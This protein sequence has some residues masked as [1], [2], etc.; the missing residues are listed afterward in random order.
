MNK[1][2]QL[3][4]VLSIFLISIVIFSCKKGQSDNKDYNR[5]SVVSVAAAANL[6]D[7]LEE[8]KEAYIKENSG[9]K[10]E[11]S[12]ASS[13]LLVQQI[14]NGAPFDLFL[15]ADTSFP[16]KLKMNNK[17]F[18]NSSVYTYGRTA[19]WSSNLDVSEGLKIVLNPKVKKIAIANPKLAPYGKNAVEALKKS[20][21]YTIIEHKIVWA[22]NINQAAQ[23][24][25]SGNADVAF[26]ALSNVMGKEMT[27]KGKFYE[28]SDNESS[29]I[30]QSGIILKGKKTTE[31]QF[32]F[33]FI[34]SEKSKRIWKKY[35]YQSEIKF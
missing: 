35:G 6:R 16:E 9:R 34:R 12:F 20:G 28:L 25:A 31:A 27:G 32:F 2:T 13:G 3:K 26:V 19:L 33:D 30:P 8:L 10:V 1:L 15:S 24:A 22:E 7:V 29:P 21:L 23:F 17:T 14:L 18:G 11:I 4:L 5:N